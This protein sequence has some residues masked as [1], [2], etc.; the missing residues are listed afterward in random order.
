MVAKFDLYGP[1]IDFRL[2]S[3]LFPLYREFASPTG[4]MTP[5]FGSW[6]QERSNELPSCC[7]SSVCGVCSNARRIVTLPVGLRKQVFCFLGRS[8][9]CRARHRIT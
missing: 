5:M 7:F 8:H 1:G 4:L 9:R 3:V 2:T 6:E